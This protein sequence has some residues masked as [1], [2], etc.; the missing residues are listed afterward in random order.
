LADS[1]ASVEL[2]LMEGIDELPGPESPDFVP[3][4]KASVLE[5]LVSFL[6]DLRG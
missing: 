5:Y 2:F 4:Q 6:R 1:G 3:D